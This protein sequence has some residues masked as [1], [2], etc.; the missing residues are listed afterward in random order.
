[1]KG[2][3]DN[4]WEKRCGVWESA[5]IIWHLGTHWLSGPTGPASSS[6]EGWPWPWASLNIGNLGGLEPNSFGDWGMTGLFSLWF[7]A[8]Q[9]RREQFWSFYYTYL[10]GH[11]KGILVLNRAEPRLPAFFL[12]LPLASERTVVSLTSSPSPPPLL[13]PCHNLSCASTSLGCI[14]TA[15]PCPPPRPTHSRHTDWLPFVRNVP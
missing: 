8:S 5:V 7:S 12:G 1:M 11:W 6:E 15:A 9:E 2:H 10:W 13:G 3:R 4:E 14:Q